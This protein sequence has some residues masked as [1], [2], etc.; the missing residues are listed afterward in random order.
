MTK[1]ILVALGL[2]AAIIIAALYFFYWEGPPAKAPEKPKPPEVTSQV[3]PAPEEKPGEKPAPAPATAPAPTPAPTPAPEAK[4]QPLP[5]QPPAPPEKPAAKPEPAPPAV[6]EALPPLEPK[7]GSGLLAGSYK[8]YASA[9]K[10]MEKLKKQ[11][12]PAFIR[13][14]NDKYQVWVG[15]FST[16][17][18]AQAAAQAL[19]GKVKIPAKVHEIETPVPK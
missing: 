8:N 9:A 14:E 19:K 12:Q 6:K 13:K 5:G 11:G 18:E 4:P 17:E 1:N 2:A 10:M 15:P 7:K 16:P 3:P